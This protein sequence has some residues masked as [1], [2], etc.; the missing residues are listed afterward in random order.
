LCAKI[1]HKF[2][3]LG[4]FETDWR[5]AYPG[6]NAVTIMELREPPD[7]RRLE[8]IFVIKYSV[9]RR[10]ARGTPDY[11]DHAT[12]L[13]LA[14]LAADFDGAKA[15]LSNSLASIREIFEPDTTARNLSLILES[16]AKRGE[17]LP[18]MAKIIDRLRERTKPK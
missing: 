7:P 5:D 11:W 17:S 8:L 1:T 15:A 10:I 12:L 2:R 13:E 6:I 18:W 9:T 14:F 4:G 16:K 3:R